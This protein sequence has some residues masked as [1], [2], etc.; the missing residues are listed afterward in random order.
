MVGVG[1]STLNVLS[2]MLEPKYVADVGC[3]LVN[4]IS[5]SD[6]S[7]LDG[8]DNTCVGMIVAEGWIGSTVCEGNNAKEEGMPAEIRVEGILSVGVGLMA[9]LLGIRE[10]LLHAQKSFRVKHWLS[11]VVSLEQELHII[12]WTLKE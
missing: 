4:V 7:I 8:D 5:I 1:S 11:V 9:I 6:G 3:V 10:K 2:S 12:P